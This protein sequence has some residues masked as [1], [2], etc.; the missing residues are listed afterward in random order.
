MVPGGAGWY[1]K[2]LPSGVVMVF[3]DRTDAG[4]RLAVRLEH[5]RG[6]SMVVLG[7]PRGG[8][9]VALEVAQ[10]LGA[11]LDVIV[12]RKLGVPFQPELG[13]GAVGED[14]VCV[15]N[16]DIAHQAGMPENVLA[17]VM[18]REQA[19]VE[20]RAASYR[21]HRPREPL[22]GRVAVIVD[23]GIATGST[24]RAA[25]QVARAQGAARV[26][27]AV[28]VAPPGW[29][30]RI[31]ANADELACLDAPGGF[32]AIGQFYAD[33][34]QTTDEQVIACLQRA[35]T[36]VSAAPASPVDPPAWGE[37]VEPAT[38][39]DP[40]GRLPDRAAE[41]TQDRDLRPRQ[42]QQPAQPPQPVRRQHP[43]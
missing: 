40:P 17:A 28:P 39:K 31:G 5:L 20:L 26:V 33:F 15:I 34:S 41:R 8:V 7:L 2:G 27:L 25:C 21:A 1:G 24:A 14:G 6:E 36:L 38:G 9:L 35:A 19:S 23:D 3:A 12:V 16:R 11:P 37:E 29:E 13:M 18:A 32:F 22:A 43:R 42:R 4:R 30:D 10:A